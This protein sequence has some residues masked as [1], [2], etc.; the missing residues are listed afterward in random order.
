MARIPQN[1][2]G[3]GA[4]VIDANVAIALAAH[5]AGR[6]AIATAEIAQYVAL[7]YVLYAPGTII[8]ETLY[9]LCNKLNNGVLTL[10]SHAAAIRNFHRSMKDIEPP[11]SGEAALVLRAEQIRAGYGCSRSADGI[12][13]ALADELSQTMPTVL[14]TFDQDLPKQAVRHAPGVS[15]KLL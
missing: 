3:T 1:K 11:P 9:A 2:A 4:V 7:G 15:V 12:Y 13:I 5:E 10:T 14:L 8:A 6:D